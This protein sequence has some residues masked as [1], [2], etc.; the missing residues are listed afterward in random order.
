MSRYWGAQIRHLGAEVAS[1]GH[2][3]KAHGT[4][5]L[6][7]RGTT[8]RDPPRHTS[9][10]YPIA[11]FRIRPCLDGTD[12]DREPPLFHNRA[13]RTTRTR[14]GRPATLAHMRGQGTL[15]FR[16]EP[17]DARDEQAAPGNERTDPEQR[18]YPLKRGIRKPDRDIVR[19]SEP[20]RHKNDDSHHK[21]DDRHGKNDDRY[22][23]TEDP[24]HTGRPL[25]PSPRRSFRS[26]RIGH[27]AKTP[28]RPPP[29]R[30]GHAHRRPPRSGPRSR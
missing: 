10:P 2:R 11:D 1:A 12:S 27:E 19:T 7:G 16:A 21:N 22:R 15:V 20:C 30:A 14:S 26:P 6:C 24:P 3:V 29:A 5:C 9:R 8:G 13:R 17:P 18:S 23:V 25:S 28:Y 4:S